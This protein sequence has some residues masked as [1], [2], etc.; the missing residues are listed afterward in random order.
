MFLNGG[1]KYDNQSMSNKD[2]DFLELKKEVAN[3]I[4]KNLKIPLALVNT[5]TMTLDNVTRSMLM[6]YD[7]AVLPI[8]NRIFNELSNF[9][10]PRYG[11]NDNLILTYDEGDIIALEPRRNEQLKVLKDMGIFTINQLRA[12]VGADPLVG[13]NAIYG[14]SSQIP[15][16]TDPDDESILP[17]Y[18]D[19]P[20]LDNVGGNDEKLGSSNKTSRARFVSVLQAKVDADGNRVFTDEEIN[21]IADKRKLT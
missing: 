13:G 17:N 1:F 11:N 8:A 6:F 4:Y 9:L 14:Q 2:M 7:N 18:D 16:A 19:L 15:M 10:L 20:A 21:K 12:K 5:E 3:A